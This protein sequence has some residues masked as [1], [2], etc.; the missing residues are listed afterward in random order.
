MNVNKEFEEMRQQY[1]KMKGGWHFDNQETTAAETK[2]DYDN[3]N[4]IVSR[5]FLAKKY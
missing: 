1:E 4:Q 5:N 2:P 3:S